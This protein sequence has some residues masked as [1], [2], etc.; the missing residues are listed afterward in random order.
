[1][2]STLITCIPIPCRLHHWLYV[3]SVRARYIWHHSHCPWLS[4]HSRFPFQLVTFISVSFLW[5]KSHALCN[6]CLKSLTWPNK[7]FTWPNKLYPFISSATLSLQLSLVHALY[8]YVWP[9]TNAKCLKPTFS[10]IKKCYS[11]SFSSLAHLRSNYYTLPFN[12]LLS[13]NACNIKGFTT[14]FALASKRTS[15]LHSTVLP[16]TLILC[17]VRFSTWLQFSYQWSLLI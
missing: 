9:N 6:L 3:N 13:V 4:G 5:A 8:F 10:N 14:V 2:T 16:P 15:R 1:M 17:F 7:L 11:V 12:K